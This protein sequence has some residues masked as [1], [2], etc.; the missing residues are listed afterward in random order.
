MSDG[1]VV[2]D[3]DLDKAKA[4][5][6]ISDI[7]KEVGSM[8]KSISG[9]MKDA[10]KNMTKYVTLPLVAMAT[11]M[12]KAAMD[13]EATEAKYYTVFGNMSDQS[14]EFIKEF[15]KLTPATKAEA[16]SMASGIQDFENKSLMLAIA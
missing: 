7:N 11:G 5:G 12:G 16:R 6:G 14:D 9:V 4:M 10:G 8:A 2:I 15:Q 1:R 3:V 13:L